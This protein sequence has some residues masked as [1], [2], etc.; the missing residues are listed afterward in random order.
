MFSVLKTIFNRY[1]SNV[2][3][4]SLIVWD[5]D[6]GWSTPIEFPNEI[7]KHAIASILYM[8]IIVIQVN[9]GGDLIRTIFHPSHL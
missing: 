7:N 5:T 3:K 4:S 9:Q 2:S 1:L 8:E 6:L